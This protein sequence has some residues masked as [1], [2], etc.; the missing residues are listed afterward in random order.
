MNAQRVVGKPGGEAGAVLTR[1]AVEQDRP[2]RRGQLGEIELH[3]GDQHR[4]PWHPQVEAN[5]RRTRFGA[6]AYALRR[7]FVRRRTGE[8]GGFAWLEQYFGGEFGMAGAGEGAA[9]A[10]AA[11]IDHRTE[12]QRCHLVQVCRSCLMVVPGTP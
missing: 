12:P 4:T 11:Q 7:G 9:L 2:A 5:H 3:R 6:G 1:D 10:V 8:A